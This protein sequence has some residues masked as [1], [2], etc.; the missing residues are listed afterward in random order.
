MGL[1]SDE[2]RVKKADAHEK[3]KLM[4]VKRNEGKK[5]KQS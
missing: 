5:E 3:K 4:R 1:M 2:G